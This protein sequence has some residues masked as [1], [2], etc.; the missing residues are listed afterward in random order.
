MTAFEGSALEAFNQ[1]RADVGLRAAAYDPVLGDVAAAHARVLHAHGQAAAEAAADGLMAWGG[2]VD[3][4]PQ[5][6]ILISVRADPGEILAHVRRAGREDL[7]EAGEPVIGAGR[8]VERGRAVSVL[9]ISDRSFHLHPLQREVEVAQPVEI[10]GRLSAGFS[11]P[12][13][14]FL[15]DGEEIHEV[16]PVEDSAGGDRVVFRW[17]PPN[18]GQVVVEILTK[19]PRGPTVGALFPLAVGVPPPT[20]FTVASPPD[21]SFIRSADNAEERLLE[22]INRERVERRFLPVV[23][24]A[25]ADGAARRFAWASLRSGVLAHHGPDGADAAGRLASVGIA[26]ARVS[27][28]LARNGSLEDAHRSLMRSLGHRQN[29]LDRGVDHVGIGVATEPPLIDGID[30]REFWIVCEFFREVPVVRHTEDR[31]TLRSAMNRR[32]SDAGLSPLDGERDLDMLAG[33]LALRVLRTR[34]V[35]LDDLSPMADQAL[36]L[37]PLRWALWGLQVYRSALPLDDTAD[38]PG[39]LDPRFTHVGI[40]LA[41]PNLGEVPDDV[42]TGVVF[43]FAARRPPGA[44]SR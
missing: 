43:V 8:R 20:E 42:R 9:V 39:I 34:S 44:R 30:K 3:P 37:S 32:R 4:N 2:G 33:R 16:G 10:V 29:I 40:G 13:L 22:L 35:N 38:A 12:H 41:Q 11:D 27:E 17:T 15:A 28:N 21:E 1:G 19:G 5:R 18:P 36:C 23:R 24:S 26:A 7:H 6:R 14:L 25:A 31:L